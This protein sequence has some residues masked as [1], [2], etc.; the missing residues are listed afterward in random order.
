MYALKD[1][2]ITL[3]T[4]G[5]VFE[6]VVAARRISFISPRVS[7]YITLSPLEY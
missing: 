6:D 3:M 2:G 7:Y 4:L 1:Y 5:W